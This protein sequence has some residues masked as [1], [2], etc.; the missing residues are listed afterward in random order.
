MK[1]KRM[2]CSVITWP[3]GG[4][5]CILSGWV[6][7]KELLLQCQQQEEPF[8]FKGKHKLL[9]LLFTKTGKDDFKMYDICTI[10]MHTCLKA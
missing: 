5:T 1:E 7:A 4:N 8:T 2:M 9:L 3:V 6:S 10:I